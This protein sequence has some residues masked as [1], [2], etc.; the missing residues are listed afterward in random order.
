MQSTIDTHNE[1]PDPPDLDYNNEYAV[2][3]FMM[4]YVI[5]EYGLGAVQGV[6]KSSKDF[7]EAIEDEMG[8][9]YRQWEND[10]TAAVENQWKTNPPEPQ[11]KNRTSV[12]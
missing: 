10:W 5:E 4:D 2:G 7:E 3:L 6:Y 12:I 1:L 8:I 9:P 11:K